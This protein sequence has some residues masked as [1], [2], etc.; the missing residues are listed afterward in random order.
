MLSGVM[1]QRGRTF[2]SKENFLLGC[3][4]KALFDTGKTTGGFM[5]EATIWKGIVI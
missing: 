5:K 1:S 2:C 4:N 3:F